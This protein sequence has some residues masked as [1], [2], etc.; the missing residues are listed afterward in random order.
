MESVNDCLI[1]AVKCAG[2]SKLVGAK[3]WP[4]LLV[5]P[6]Q[7]KLLDAL[8][9]DRPHH[10]TPEQAGFIFRL[11]RDAGRYEAWGAYCALAGF[12]PGKALTASDEKA[13]LQRQVLA[14]GA[15]LQAL[16]QQV[17]RVGLS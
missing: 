4:E 3:L 13:D 11:A 8:N 17:A 9:P 12:A 1:E 16:M 2:G 5:E 10:L 6:A 15:Q 14:M 7:R